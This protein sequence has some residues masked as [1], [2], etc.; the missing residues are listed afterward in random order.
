MSIPTTLKNQI[1]GSHYQ[2]Y[3]L[4]PLEFAEKVG[5][6][7]ACFS[8]FK[9]VCRYKDKNGLEDLQK[10]IHCLAIFKECGIERD[11]IIIDS[12]YMIEFLEQFEESQAQ[13]LFA[14]IQ[15]QCLKSNVD[16]AFNLINVLLDQ[17]K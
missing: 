1:G 17:Y 10:A 5:L 3:R 11:L 14:I 15:C 13:A 8:A 6:T 2:K 7:A 9:Y 16:K 12:Q 4:Q